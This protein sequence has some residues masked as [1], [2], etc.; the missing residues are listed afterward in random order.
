MY[1]YDNSV[2]EKKVNKKGLPILCKP[3][4]SRKIDS[5]RKI[6]I[7]GAKRSSPGD[8]NQT[9]M[10]RLIKK[11]KTNIFKFLLENSLLSKILIKADKEKYKIQN[12]IKIDF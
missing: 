7:T 6:E 1:K 8:L 10:K 2:T 12:I 4:F 5:K 9:E 3:L 11:E